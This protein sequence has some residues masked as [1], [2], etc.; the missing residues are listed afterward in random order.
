MAV[1]YRE[2]LKMIAER[3]WCEYCESEKDDDGYKMCQRC[4]EIRWARSKRW[5]AKQDPEVIKAKNR[6]RQQRWYHR[7]HLSSKRNRAQE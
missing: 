1:S 5:L 3:R 7:H 4:R 6:A 2:R